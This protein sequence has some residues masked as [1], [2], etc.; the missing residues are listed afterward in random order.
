MSEYFRGHE[1]VKQGE[2]YVYADNGESV[3]DTW[4]QRPCGHCGLPNTP[5]GYDGCIGEVKDAINACYGHGNS[6]EAYV[7]Y[8]DGRR[9]GG[10][11]AL[12]IFK[13]E[14]AS[15]YSAAEAYKDVGKAKDDRIGT[16]N[17]D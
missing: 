9:V 15:V 17:I 5:E 11:E 6:E 13:C 4:T 14:G 8:G 3:A 7:Q 16:E 2:R 1:I 10:S 12:E